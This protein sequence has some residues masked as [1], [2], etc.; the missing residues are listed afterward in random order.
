MGIYKRGK[1]WWMRLTFEGRQLRRSTET[2]NKRLAQKVHAKVITEITEGKWFDIKPEEDKTFREMMDKYLEEYSILKTPNGQCRDR[3]I[4]EH[5]LGFFGDT[6]LK[7]ITPPLIVDYK[8]MRRK[9]G[10]KPATI[11]RELCLI[12][13]AFNLAIREWEWV[14]KNPVSRVSRERFNNQIDRWLSSK[15]EAR[16]LEASPG[17][18]REVIVF[19]LNTGMR[20][21][22]ILDLRWPY[23]D[24]GKRTAAVM[25]SKNGDRRTIPLNEAALGVLALKSKVRHIKSDYVFASKVGTRLEKRNLARAFYQAM[26][27]AVVEDFRFHDL[28]HTFATRLAQAGVDIYTIAKLLGHKDI[29]MTQR[30]AHHSTESL[31]GGVDVLEEFSTILA[32][33]GKNQ[34]KRVTRKAVTP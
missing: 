24:R 15:E 11:E 32:Q 33:S 16:L 8:A 30:Y 12:K 31:R 20:Q 10:S 22:E 9:K 26:D 1:V 27:R 4:S 29:R 28:R 34:E 6:L 17:W 14:D 7:A 18:L 19:A 3:V 5:L 2:T 23:V 13:R 21:G 25:R